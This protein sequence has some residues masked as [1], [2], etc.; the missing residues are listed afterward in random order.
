MKTHGDAKGFRSP[1]ACADAHAAYRQLPGP[2]ARK[3]LRGKGFTVEDMSPTR[4]M[5]LTSG[6]QL[7]DSSL[8]VEA[9]DAIPKLCVLVSQSADFL[10]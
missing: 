3:L 1:D 2:H 4:R 5:M 9:G 6:W 10:A 8:A 7:I